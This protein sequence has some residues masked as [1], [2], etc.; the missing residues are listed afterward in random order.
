MI[1][2]V[3]WNIAKRHDSW[4]ELVKMD[5]DVAL[6]QEGGWLPDDVSGIDVGPKESYDSHH[7]NSDWWK[8]RWSHLIER[9]PMV[10]K[11]SDR[12]DVAWFRQVSPIWG[13][14]DDEIGVSGIGTIA[15]ARVTPKDGL[16]E[17]FIAVSMYAR[18]LGPHPSTGSSWIYG[19]AS[20]HRIISDLSAFIGN[21][22][23]ATHRIVAAGDLNMFYGY[24]DGGAPYWEARYRSVFER[25]NAIGL[26][27][28]G[29]QAPNGRQAEA[30]LPGE[31]SDSRNVVTYSTRSNPAEADNRQLDFAFASRGFHESIKVRAL[32]EVDE[33]GPS[34][35]CRI[36]IQVDG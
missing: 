11:L 20:A 18:W 8:D 12:V 21:E 36:L 25:I 7:W 24:G 16:T 4:R 1:R 13:G 22:N 27:F 3:S 33:W 9:W 32:N 2:V 5:A 26:E 6:V 10:V 15:A 17:S 34:D 19:D 35:H 28:I 23:P 30:R 14:E 29:P 31:P